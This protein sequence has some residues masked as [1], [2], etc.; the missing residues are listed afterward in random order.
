MVS[1][2]EIQEATGNRFHVETLVGASSWNQAS[3]ERLRKRSSSEGISHLCPRDKF[4]EPGILC[5]ILDGYLEGSSAT[6]ECPKKHVHGP[7]KGLTNADRSSSRWPRRA[8]AQAVIGGVENDPIRRHE[9]HPAEDVEMDLSSADVPD[10]EFPEERHVEEVRVP[11]RYPKIA[12]SRF[13]NW[14]SE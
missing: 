13:A 8:W 9:A 4:Q 11:K 3:I 1:L 2:C 10:D 14:W 7:V 12:S 5:Q 6:R